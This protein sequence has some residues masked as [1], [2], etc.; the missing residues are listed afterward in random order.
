[1]FRIKREEEIIKYGFNFMA[2]ENNTFG[3]VIIS[4]PI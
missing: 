2:K 4:I 1:M 3:G